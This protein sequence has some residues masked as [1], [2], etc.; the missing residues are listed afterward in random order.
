MVILQIHNFYKTPGGECSVVR[1]E[2][3]L[4]EA[5]GH[6]IIQ[7][8]IDSAEIAGY[9][10]P[11]KV[12]TFL[13]IPY[14]C[15]SAYRLDRFLKTHQPDVAHVH[16]V[17]PLLSPSIYGVLKKHRIPVVQTVHN[18]RFLCPNGLLF[19][20]GRVCDD[21][22]RVG[23]FAAVKNTCM[24]GSYTTS[25]LY[26]AAIAIAWRTGNIPG[27][28]DR[29]IA[30][31][32]FGADMLHRGGVPAEKVRICGNFIASMAPAPQINKEPYILYLGRLSPEKGVRTLLKAMG[33]VPKAVS[34][35]IA[36]SGPLDGE[37]KDFVAHHPALQVQ[38][39]GFVSGAQKEQLIAKALCSVVPSEW[40]ENFPISV[41]E[42]LA[43]GTPV[44][45]SRIGGLPELITH[46]TTGLLYEPGNAEA[47][48][49]SITQLVNDPQE[50]QRMASAALESARTRF[51]PEVHLQE[52]NA[53]YNEC[54]Q[55][56]L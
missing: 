11:S 48:S 55:K 46:G 16:N 15:S 3:S 2:R 56:R 52:L 45:A 42:S 9:S 24:H 43:Q 34:L 33:N 32:L 29:F 40:Y 44:I 53:I 7:H 27:N 38:F 49:Q 50:A 25:A 28:I 22:L 4:L 20:Q 31:N 37:L 36:G 26:A 17:F 8:T 23:K 30:L 47:L 18:Y 12:L 39:L 6:N 14:N 51:S 10:Y 13:Q 21:C 35:K 19:T 1:A 54:L 41:L 5:A